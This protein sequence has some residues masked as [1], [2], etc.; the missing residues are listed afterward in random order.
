MKITND[1]FYL[2]LINCPVLGQVVALHVAD[3]IHAGRGTKY[4]RQRYTV[5][6]RHWASTVRGKPFNYVTGKE[7]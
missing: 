2:G 6:E 5:E 7:I 3:L 4:E 1:L